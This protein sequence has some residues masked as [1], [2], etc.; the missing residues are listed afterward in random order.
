MCVELEVNVTCWIKFARHRF[1]FPLFRRA[2][3]DI[4]IIRWYCTPGITDAQ[5]NIDHILE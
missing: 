5:R 3:L 1:H 4:T 2:C